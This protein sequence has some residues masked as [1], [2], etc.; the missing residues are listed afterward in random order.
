LVCRMYA[1]MHA[2]WCHLIGFIKL[3]YSYFAAGV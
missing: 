3:V 2:V 1:W